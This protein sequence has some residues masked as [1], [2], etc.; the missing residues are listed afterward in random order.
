MYKCYI[1]I[2]CREQKKQNKKE[3]KIKINQIKLK[4]IMINGFYKNKR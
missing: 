1:F 2:D 4:T 3:R